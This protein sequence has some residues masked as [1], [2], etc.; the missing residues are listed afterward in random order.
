MHAVVIDDVSFR[1]GD[2]VALDGIS[3]DVRAGSITGFLGPNGGGK[4]TLFGLLS[5]LLPLQSGRVDVLGYDMRR[6]ATEC[7]REIGVTFQAPALDRRL[8]VREN[9]VHHGRL[10]GLSGRDLSVRVSSML[11]QFAVEDRSGEMVETL[12]GG[13]KRRVELAKCLL[14]RP[15]LLML[16]EPSNGLDPGARK[17]LWE[18]L[19]QVRV[20][21]GTTVLVATHLMEEAERCDCLALL[22]SGKLVASGS[23]SELRS[24]IPGTTISII[25]D[26]PEELRRRLVE[27]LGVEVRRRGETLQIQH[28]D[29]Q[30]LLHRIVDRFSGEFQSVALGRATLEDVFMMRTGHTLAGENE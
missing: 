30:S 11:S 21:N 23:P 3:F 10:Y 24:G 28:A 6:Q 18:S 15:R 22:D 8:S 14:C 2:R 5:S 27:E 9:L 25:C 12:S 29:G 16:D 19:E 20:E 7:R 17:S 1:Y 4:S 26:E 13:L